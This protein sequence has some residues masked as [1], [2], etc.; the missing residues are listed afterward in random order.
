MQSVNLTT[1]GEP[2]MKILTMCA[3]SALALSA[4]A[5]A[6]AA[7]ASKANVYRVFNDSVAPADQD[8]YEAAGKAYN[9]CLHDHG[10]KF[11]WNA[12]N[13]ETGDVYTYSYVAGPYNWADFDAMHAAGKACD[14]TW[15]KMA[16]PHLKGE[17]SAFLVGHPEMSHMPKDSDG[18]PPHGMIEVIDFTLKPGHEA[19]EAFANGAKKI[20]AAAGKS[21]WSGHFAIYEIRDGGDGAPNYLV[22]LPA[23]DWADVGMEA[24]PTLWKMVEGVNGKSEADAMRK[25]INDS[26]EKSSSHVDSYNAD[27]TYTAA[28]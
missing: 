8:A 15:R 1:Q 17:T 24:N 5:S 11:T 19:H 21:N 10:F 16:N 14:A 3:V 12:W 26:I 7:D 18:S 20:A 28:K 27:L 6:F 4:C 23:K 13:H 2:V 25:S 9:Q 22:L